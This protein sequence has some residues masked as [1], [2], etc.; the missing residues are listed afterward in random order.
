MDRE[1][2]GGMEKTAMREKG[3]LRHV[4]VFLGLAGWAFGHGWWWPPTGGAMIVPAH[5]NSSDTVT[6]TLKGDWPDTCIPTGS[7]VSLQGNNIFID[8]MV[9]GQ[10]GCLTINTPWEQTQTVGPLAPGLYIVWAR[11]VYGSGISTLYSLVALS[12][13]STQS[14]MAAL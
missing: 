3:I 1:T 2:R 9:H 11:L 6:I 7:S 8:V 12:P 13:T 10:G 14:L 5:P 4:L